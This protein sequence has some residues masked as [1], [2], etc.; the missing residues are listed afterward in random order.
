LRRRVDHAARLWRA[1]AGR[2]VLACG[3]PPGA[4]P[5]EA[6]AAHD[7]LVAAGVPAEAILLEEASRDTLGNARHAAPI[8]AAGG[9]DAAVVVTDGFHMPR[10]LLAFRL[11]G[12]RARGAAAPWG[13][14]T[15]R[16]RRAAAVL[17]EAAAL[18][19]LVVRG[20]ALRLSRPRRR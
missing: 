3:G 11:M 5:T 9:F 6:R 13:P 8:L 15:S 1:G 18:P 14:P 16:T 20:L 12:V 4:A 2:E 7:A 17:R 19:V 10:A